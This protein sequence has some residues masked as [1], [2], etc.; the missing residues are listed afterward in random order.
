MT[1]PMV[2]TPPRSG[3]PE[4][5]LVGETTPIRAAPPPVTTPESP[6]TR[7]DPLPVG[8][9]PQYRGSLAVSTRCSSVSAAG[10]EPRVVVRPQQLFSTESESARSEIATYSYICA[11]GFSPEGEV[12][13]K[14]AR[15]DGV[16]ERKRVWTDRHGVGAWER[17]SMPGD[18]LGTYRVTARQGGLEVQGSYTVRPASR[19]NSLISPRTGVGG[20][21]FRIAL[22][23]FEPRE[24]V[25]LH[26]YRLSTDGWV[27]DHGDDYATTLIAG[28]DERGEA[29]YELRTR[30]TDPAMQYLVLTEHPEYPAVEWFTVTVALYVAAVDQGFEG[31]NLRQ[32]PTKESDIL[33]V[34]PN[35]ASVQAEARPSEGTVEGEQW[36]RVTYEGREG[37]VLGSLLSRRRPGAASAP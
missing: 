6:L 36:Y 19:P 7:R 9:P 29:I 32:M 23:G 25:S 26:V 1:E 14:I 13:F 21:T 10:E 31:A 2:V 3:G 5:P 8:V 16:V 20:T 34:I 27:G 35:G 37:F 22:A 30:P 4:A 15:P 12:R 17:A 18:P 33:V 28:A 24:Q 11:P